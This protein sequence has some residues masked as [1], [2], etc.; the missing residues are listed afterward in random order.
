VNQYPKTTQAFG[1]ATALEQAL[2]D[3]GGRVASPQ[4]P[5]Q[6]QNTEFYNLRQKYYPNV[7]LDFNEPDALSSLLGLLFPSNFQLPQAPAATPNTLT[8]T[9]PAQ[10]GSVFT[11]G[12][13]VATTP[14]PNAD[15]SRFTQGPPNPSELQQIPSWVAQG[16]T[17]EQALTQIRGSAVQ[18]A[19]GG[20]AAV[21]PEVANDTTATAAQFPQLRSDPVV[22]ARIAALEQKGFTLTP[23]QR[24]QFYDTYA[25]QIA[26]GLWSPTTGYKT[27]VQP[28]QEAPA[29]LVS[30]ATA[31]VVAQ[32]PTP[33]YTPFGGAKPGGGTYTADDYIAY[34]ASAP[35]SVR[36]YSIAERDA[37]TAASPSVAK[38]R[39]VLGIEAGGYRPLIEAKLIKAEQAI[40][41]LLSDSEINQAV[42][43]GDVFG[44]LDRLAIQASG[45]AAAPVRTSVNYGRT[46]EDAPAF[47][48]RPS[49]VELVNKGQLTGDE[50]QTAE[51]RMQEDPTLLWSLAALERIKARPGGTTPSAAQKTNSI[52][53]GGAAGESY[54]PP[55]PVQPT[56]I[57][58][59]QAAL[60][61]QA[62]VTQSF[63]P[64]PITPGAIGQPTPSPAQEVMS[65]PSK[66]AGVVST[67]KK[68]LDIA[69]PILATIAKFYPQLKV[70]ALVA[71]MADS[72]VTI[73]NS[74]MG[75]DEKDS[76]ARGRI[77]A[78]LGAQGV[79]LNSPEAQA[80]VELLLDDLRSGNVG[81][82]DNSSS[83]SPS[84]ESGTTRTKLPG[85]T[86]TKAVPPK[87]K[88]DGGP[89]ENITKTGTEDVTLP[90]DAAGGP[91]GEQE[92]DVAT[93]DW[94]N[95]TGGGGVTDTSNDASRT[96]SDEERFRRHQ[97]AEELANA[98]RLR[99]DMDRR[100][101]AS[102]AKNN[103]DTTA[104]AP[105][106]TTG[107]TLPA[108]LGLDELVAKLQGLVSGQATSLPIEDKDTLKAL[109]TRLEEL[110]KGTATFNPD[111]Q[112]TIS[113]RAA[114]KTT[115]KTSDDLDQ[116]LLAAKGFTPSS[117]GTTVTPATSGTLQGIIGS[118]K[119]LTPSDVG[120][121]VSAPKINVAGA[122]DTMST[123]IDALIKK[124]ENYVP[125]DVSTNVAAQG[126]NKYLPALA[127]THVSS[128]DT[129]I[130]GTPVN[131]ASVGQA[132]LVELQGAIDTLKKYVPTDTSTQVM[133]AGVNQDIQ[134]LF[135]QAAETPV[136]SEQYGSSEL[137]TLLKQIRSAAAGE[138]TP[139][140][141]AAEEA[142]IAMANRAASQFLNTDR[143]G[144]GARGI[145]GSGAAGALA[146]RYRAQQLAN[147]VDQLSGQ[148]YGAQ[149]SA[150]QQL[151]GI[152]NQ[153]AQQELA[154]NQQ[155]L[156]AVSKAASLTH[157]QMALNQRA[158]EI[159]V[160]LRVD[161]QTAMNMARLEADKAA[162][163]LALQAQT[164]GQERENLIAQLEQQASVAQAG[165]Q[166]QANIESARL[167]TQQALANQQTEVDAQKAAASI[168][169]ESLALQQRATEISAQLRV[170]QQTA[171]NMA[172]VEA[173]KAA[174][175]LAEQV[176]GTKQATNNLRTQ[177]ENQRNIAQG[178]LDLEAG[179]TSQQLALDQSK[180]NAANRLSGLQTA[181][182]LA[183]DEAA[184]TQRASE[185]STQLGVEQQTATTMARLEAMQQTQAGASTIAGNE[186]REQELTSGERARATDQMLALLDSQ[187]RTGIQALG[188]QAQVISDTERNNLVRTQ[189]QE[190][191]KQQG[192]DNVHNLAQFLSGEA[193]NKAQ[194]S[195]LGEKNLIA[196]EAIQQRATEVLEGYAL[197][198]AKD[199][200]EIDA[201]KIRIKNEKDAN[202]RAE[203]ESL[204]KSATAVIATGDAVMEGLFGEGWLG[205]L[206]N[207]GDN[208]I[209]K[210]GD[211]SLVGGKYGKGG[212]ANAK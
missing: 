87:K 188:T 63:V 128:A 32:P 35:G 80:V 15:W 116:D 182:G 16:Y 187:S 133:E 180:A 177:V 135:S 152:Q 148:R 108:N 21:A 164:L 12:T 19:L 8:T 130:E 171:M 93:I 145:S 4:T 179:T 209:T 134:R 157:D 52:F 154:S 137:Q 122:V 9:E 189:V 1:G 98:A 74:A 60:A 129:S 6:Q 73:A 75:P 81:M 101:A 83:G 113:E 24:N 85:W 147:L 136:G 186:L 193:I 107:A 199:T 102:A 76:A 64:T 117:V 38:I 79:N 111:L 167:G 65:A 3:A 153:L 207:I 206:L 54:S 181:G 160:Q 185:I 144:A 146:E 14:Y 155:K 78:A 114:E 208:D 94:G 48:L 22:L 25:E 96:L 17:P 62:P 2:L 191:I 125:A 142:Q 92:G 141:Q 156:D 33:A 169:Q 118:L 131:A 124:L 175:G 51:A 198:R 28:P 173:T 183:Q 77:T 26:N 151:P 138:T 195:D 184:L 34:A 162:A 166:S 168:E 95:S 53:P 39:T 140:Q 126:S 66:A 174:G 69:T 110:G 41:R 119:S 123:D 159:T 82:V 68:V 202:K 61:K 203:Y 103:A 104:T 112:K 86:P 132:S 46:T 30:P 70:P 7:N 44:A 23:E 200:A 72:V 212:D 57:S 37:F 42:T 163:N 36:Q 194:I 139:A 91:A 149:Q 45:S 40:G 170:D 176:Y 84:G 31:P 43:S 29:A 47:T 192:F 11:T 109:L 211:T 55:A 143:F 115:F 204:L 196:R 20:P 161:Q 89:I 120:T 201:L 197:Q 49:L 158:S 127:G 58:D 99:A 210:S 105:P 13:S 56:G 10:P 150:L 178:Q 5:P 121:S 50:A 100:T 97:E 172:K 27:P 71:G 88:D 205:R 106:P 18:P 90:D 165:Y 67:A 59:W 190:S